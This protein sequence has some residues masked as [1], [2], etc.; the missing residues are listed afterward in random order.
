MQDPIAHYVDTLLTP[1]LEGLGVSAFPGA[2]SAVASVRWLRFTPH[3]P[4]G[5]W[6]IVCS[7]KSS[8]SRKVFGPRTT[9]P[10]SS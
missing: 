2:T 9:E 7:Q 8:N 5:S 10:W 1:Q 4:P 6:L 3:S